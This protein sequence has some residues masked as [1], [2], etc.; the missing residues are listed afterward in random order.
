MLPQQVRQSYQELKQG[1]LDLQATLTAETFNRVALKEN[2]STL[3]VIFNS[4][5]SNLS[6]ER[7]NLESLPR[8]QSLQTEMHRLLRL[9]EMDVMFCLAARQATTAASRQKA[10]CDRINTMIGYCDALLQAT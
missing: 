3:Q 5:M 10:M 6:N 1:L 7:L 8:W 4:Q 9:I 2:F